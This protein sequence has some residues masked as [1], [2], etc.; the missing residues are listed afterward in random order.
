MPDKPQA[1]LEGRFIPASEARI[2]IYDAG[3]ALGATVTEQLRTFGGRLFRLQDHLE[4]LGHSLEITGRP[5]ATAGGAQPAMTLADIGRVAEELVERNYQ[6]VAPGSDLALVMFVTPGPHPSLVEPEGAVERAP[7]VCLHTLELP[8]K[9]WAEKYRRGE[10][11]VTTDVRQVPASCWPPELKC[12]S[13]MHYF[14]ADSKAAAIDPGAR[15]L[16]LDQSGHVTEAST[17]NILYCQDGG[18]VTP[19]Q[20]SVLHGISLAETLRLAEGLDISLTERAMTVA[21]VAAAQEVLLT[22]TPFCI[23]P[24]T[25]LNGRP[26]GSGKPGAI[27]ERLLGAWNEAVGLDIAQQAERF[28]GV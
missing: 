2:P 23:L 1:F 9:R 20:D 21:D 26:I 7:L 10:R 5:L 27:Y 19:P 14:L 12:R 18:L 16:L 6:L 4:R 22:S 17:A 15:A 11:L 8:F 24:V 25:R 28:E 3:F 13:R